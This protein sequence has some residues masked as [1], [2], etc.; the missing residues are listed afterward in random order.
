LT[1]RSTRRLPHPR[2]TGRRRL[3]HRRTLGPMSAANQRRHQGG[4]GPPPHRF[5]GGAARGDALERVVRIA[6]RAGHT[7]A[8][9][10]RQALDVLLEVLFS[11][12]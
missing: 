5:A 10:V 12:L 11:S 4:R 2:S 1:T 8:S 3:A 6:R 9:R 7:M